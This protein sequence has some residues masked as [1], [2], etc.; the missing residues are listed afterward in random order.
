MRDFPW[1]NLGV[2]V[3]VWAT[4]ITCWSVPHLNMLMLFFFLHIF[5]L[6]MLN[7]S[8]FQQSLEIHHS[9]GT[10]IFIVY[11]CFIFHTMQFTPFLPFYVKITLTF[12]IKYGLKF[13]YKHALWR[14]CL[15]FHYTF[16]SS[17]HPSQFNQFVCQNNR[18]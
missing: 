16:H 17:S 7:T 14:L 18:L 8:G 10:R 3:R 15:I 13:K 5:T 6:L 11:L 12:F 9:Y 1:K 2:T 4:H